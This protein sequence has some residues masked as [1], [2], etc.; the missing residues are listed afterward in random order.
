MPRIFIDGSSTAYGLWGGAEGGWAERLKLAH[1]PDRTNPDGKRPLWK[2]YNLAT[3]HR[4]INDIIEQLPHFIDNYRREDKVLVAVVMVGQ[5]ES[6]YSN[7]SQEPDIPLRFFANNLRHLADLLGEKSCGLIL[8]GTTPVVE[9]KT[10]AVGHLSC[11]YNL[12]QRILYDEAI[13]DISSDLNISYV[14]LMRPPRD[15]QKMNIEIMDA[16]GLHPN[17]HGHR[18][19]YDLIHDAVEN[20]VAR[21]RS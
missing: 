10:K 11:L 15:A 19:I 1:M 18:I 8:T 7:A 6:R 21:I 20:E 5:I 13:Q 3:P 2:V 16:D 9:E 17:A 14:H 12:E 4:T